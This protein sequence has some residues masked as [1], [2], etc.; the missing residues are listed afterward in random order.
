EAFFFGVQRPFFVEDRV[1]AS[2]AQY[3]TITVR[4]RLCSDGGRQKARLCRTVQ[5]CGLSPQEHEI[6]IAVLAQVGLRDPLRPGDS[7]ARAPYRLPP[8]GSRGK[9]NCAPISPQCPAHSIRCVARTAA[10]KFASASPSTCRRRRSGC[11]V[12]SPAVAG[13]CRPCAWPSLCRSHAGF[14]TPVR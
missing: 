9:P 8:I 13:S 12:P 5:V 14:G 2:A 6:L 10:N 11:P 4:Q 3:P 1:L 7:S